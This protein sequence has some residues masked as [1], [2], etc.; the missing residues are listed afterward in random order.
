VSITLMQSLVI[1][2]LIVIF[3]GLGTIHYYVD[4]N[5]SVFN[6]HICIMAFMLIAI[7][8][9]VLIYC[10][11]KWLKWVKKLKDEILCRNRI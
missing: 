9:I 1:T 8:L 2:S 3:L 10:S 6:W 4:V 11:A 5:T 7:A